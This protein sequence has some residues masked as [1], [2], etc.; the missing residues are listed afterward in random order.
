MLSSLLLDNLS[1]SPGREDAAQLYRVGR[2]T[3]ELEASFA[4]GY[5]PRCAIPIAR[6]IAYRLSATFPSG[7]SASAA[8]ILSSLLLLASYILRCAIPI[9]RRIAYRLSATFPSGSSSSAAR[10][11]S[12]LLLLASLQRESVQIRLD[13]VHL[14]LD[15][16]QLRL[17]SV[18]LRVKSVC[19]RIEEI[20]SADQLHSL[21]TP[22]NH[23]S[24]KCSTLLPGLQLRFSLLLSFTASA[25]E[26][27]CVPGSAVRFALARACCALPF[28]PSTTFRGSGHFNGYCTSPL[29]R[30]L[31][32]VTRRSSAESCPAVHTRFIP[33]PVQLLVSLRLE[34]LGVPVV[35][36][37]G[38]ISVV[39]LLA[40]SGTLTAVVLLTSS[41]SPSSR[42]SLPRTFD[43]LIVLDEDGRLHG[44]RNERIRVR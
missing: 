33:N 26:R 24:H 38:E 42:H 19:L 41:S 31:P 28:Y 11:L 8:R 44:T 35:E 1:I 30:V 20:L 23:H 34:S 3:S 12:S 14:R 32:C 27:A 6:R 43:V 16:V 5:I 36:R 21:T 7:S 13:S 25:C 37:N 9:A 22:Q 40:A 4:D 39:I 18:Q 17:E 2:C 15:S 29:L 10:I